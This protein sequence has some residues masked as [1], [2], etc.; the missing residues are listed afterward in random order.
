MYEVIVYHNN[1]E[2]NGIR[3]ENVLRYKHNGTTF[4][5]YCE[6]DETLIYPMVN[7]SHVF[8]KKVS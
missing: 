1:E 7:V 5:L 3:S 8:I 6:N 4:T 2:R